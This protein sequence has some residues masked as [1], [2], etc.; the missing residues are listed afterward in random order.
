MTLP[1]ERFKP[2]T[3]TA[4]LSLTVV[5]PQALQ[6]D[7]NSGS[8]QTPHVPGPQHHRRTGRSRPGFKDED[9]LGFNDDY[10]N[11]LNKGDRQSNG[12]SRFHDPR[13]QT[14]AGRCTHAWKDYAVELPASGRSIQRCGTALPRPTD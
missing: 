3:D 7:G 6:L 1:S 11:I 5:P 10:V 4:T 13:L 9:A 2:S 12:E 14:G 8:A